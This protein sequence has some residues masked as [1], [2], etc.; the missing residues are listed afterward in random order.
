MVRD[1]AGISF[2]GQIQQWLS[3]ATVSENLA[4]MYREM[5]DVHTHLARSDCGLVGNRNFSVLT[6]SCTHRNARS[7]LVLGVKVLYHFYARLD[8]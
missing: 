8:G 6:D 7:K 4:F 5:N 2:G 3:A 1:S